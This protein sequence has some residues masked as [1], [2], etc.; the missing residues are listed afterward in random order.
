M[1]I[2]QGFPGRLASDWVG[3]I[4][5]VAGPL[6]AGAGHGLGLGDGC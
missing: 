2:T 5:L 3:R 1:E 4:F 6:L